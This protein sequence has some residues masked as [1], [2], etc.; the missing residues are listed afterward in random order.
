MKRRIAALL[1]LMLLLSGCAMQ[2]APETT[3]TP[4]PPEGMELSEST[5]KRREDIHALLICAVGYDE[6]GHSKLTSLN[7]LVLDEQNDISLLTIPKDTRVTVEQYDEAGSYQY[8]YYGAISDVY[9]AAQSA[10]LGEKKT[11]E[12]VSSLL[13]GVRLDHYVMLNVV[14]LEQLV[15]KNGNLMIMV[16]DSIA[17]YGI[18][19]GFQ[20]IAPKVRAFASYSYLNSLGGVEYAGT[21]P[22]K[23]QRHQ[24]LIRTLMSTS[25]RKTQAMTNEEKHE[26]VQG[27]LQC[28][29]TDMTA[30]DML[31]WL[32][33]EELNFGD[34]G[35]LKG[36]KNER[37]NE[38]YWIHDQ[39]ALKDW[40]LAKFYLT[41]DIE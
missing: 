23:L 2:K 8:S 14:Q 18:P 25:A 22:Y 7:V 12:A 36:Q 29:T 1:V 3:A 37:R 16:E 27:L 9:Y 28:V 17:E 15:E 11:M 10:H 33:D 4:P 6:E 30:E 38:S 32:E 31:V 13:G 39:N 20:N 26:Y 35:I 41:D 40:V 21:D 5:L 24:L 34:V 19:E